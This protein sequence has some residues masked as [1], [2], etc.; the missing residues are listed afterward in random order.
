MFISLNPP[1]TSKTGTIEENEAQK[2]KMTL[3]VSTDNRRWNLNEN[4]LFN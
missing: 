1:V 3:P 2:G 4:V